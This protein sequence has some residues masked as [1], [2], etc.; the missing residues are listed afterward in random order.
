MALHEYDVLISNDIPF[1]SNIKAKLESTVGQAI[2]LSMQ[3]NKAAGQ[4]I[5]HMMML[6][7]GSGM[8]LTL[9]ERRLLLKTSRA[10]VQGQ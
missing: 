6:A 9:K 1:G 4:R 8:S 3:F 7:F 2:R 10:I 5:Q